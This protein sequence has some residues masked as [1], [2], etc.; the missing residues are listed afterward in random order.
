MMRLAVLFARPLPAEAKVRLRLAVGAMAKTGRVRFVRGDH[1][2]WVFAEAVPVCDLA[3]ALAAE[4]LEPE[5]I[6]T[7]LDPD[8]DAAL[9]EHAVAGERFKP[10]GR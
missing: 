2:A 9:A 5:N 4:G 1:E 8:S 7:T 10:I 3:A 6:V